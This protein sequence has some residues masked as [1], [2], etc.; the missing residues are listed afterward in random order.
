M[1]FEPQI[2]AGNVK[3]K[4]LAAGGGFRES[5]RVLVYGMLSKQ[6]DDTPDTAG[7]EAAAHDFGR[8]TSGFHRPCSGSYRLL[9]GASRG[10][11]GSLRI[12]AALAGT[13]VLRACISNTTTGAFPDCR[14][15]FQEGAMDCCSMHCCSHG[16]LF[17][18]AA[19]DLEH[20]TCISGYD[21]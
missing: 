13:A 7:Q 1:R 9:R 19:M 21:A 14:S 17:T 8:R 11:D 16:H 15:F 2:P 4:P 12:G 10:G 18:R 5:G 6:L 20:C 3:R